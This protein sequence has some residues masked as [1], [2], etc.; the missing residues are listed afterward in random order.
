MEEKSSSAKARLKRGGPVRSKRAIN[1][2][3]VASGDLKAIDQPQAPLLTKSIGPVG[4]AQIQHFPLIPDFRTR[5]AAPHPIVMSTP[6]KG[7]FSLDGWD[8][9]QQARQQNHPNIVCEIYHTRSDSKIEIALH[10]AAVRSMPQGGTCSHAEMVANTVLLLGMLME[11]GEKLEVFSHGGARR[12]TGFIKVREE[13]VITVLVERLGRSRKSIL[14]NLQHGEYLNEQALHAAIEAD[15]PKGFFEA[16]QQGKAALVSDLKAAKRSE[17]EIV[18]VVSAKM[19]VWL[20]EATT[21]VPKEISPSDNPQVV[22]TTEEKASRSSQPSKASEFT[23]WA[24]NE[25]A[26]SEPTIDEGRVRSEIRGIGTE[27]V[28]LSESPDLISPEQVQAVQELTVQL[29][30]LTA[31][32]RHLSNQSGVT[33]EGRSNG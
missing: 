23:H 2:F 25:A 17:A 10:K 4:I 26:T 19:L 20:K 21:P 29:S 33:K 7:I 9:I 13:D 16:V 32:L 12:G 31:Y 6:T 14:K 1:N 3:Q 5:T 24:G 22:Q 11:S 15:V 28:R 18:E 8:L 30:R 27:L